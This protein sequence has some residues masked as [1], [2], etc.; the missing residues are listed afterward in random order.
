[1]FYPQ[2]DNN[3]LLYFLLKF[4]RLP[5][6]KWIVKPS[7]VEF[8]IWCEVETKCSFLYRQVSQS[9]SCG[10]HHLPTYLTS[11]PFYNENE[12]PN[13]RRAVSK[14]SIWLNLC[15]CKTILITGALW[16]LMLGKAYPLTLVL[17]NFFLAICKLALPIN[18]RIS[19]ST[20]PK[21]AVDIF[22]RFTMNL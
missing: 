8:C 11:L 17:L 5:F 14:F 2:G 7:R 15:Q 18:L 20:S 6:H 16:V 1:M 22:I 9:N 3:N 10:I 19:P 12:F 4:W 13:M 21:H